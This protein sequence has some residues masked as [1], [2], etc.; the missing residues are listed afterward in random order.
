MCWGA[1]D[2]TF[3]MEYQ[4]SGAQV[5]VLVWKDIQMKWEHS[6]C[7]A[8]L[9]AVMGKLHSTILHAANRPHA[10]HVDATKISSD[11]NAIKVEAAVGDASGSIIWFLM[12][13]YRHRGYC[14]LSHRGHTTKLCQSLKQRFSLKAPGHVYYPFSIQRLR[15]H[16]RFI[17]AFPVSPG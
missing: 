16:E 5:K 3:N 9:F 13:V 14:G 7:F 10:E 11:C 2:V 1:R 17:Y 12:S 6:G 4:V 8:S 15:L